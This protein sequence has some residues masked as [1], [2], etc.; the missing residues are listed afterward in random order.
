MDGIKIQSNPSINQSV[1]RSCQFVFR[2]KRYLSQYHCREGK[3]RQAGALQ[4]REP[5]TTTALN[6]GPLPCFASVVYFSFS[7]TSI[8]GPVVSQEITQRKSHCLLTADNVKN[9][10]QHSFCAIS[11]QITRSKLCHKSCPGHKLK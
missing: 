5:G 11:L 7:M 10:N 4:L 2:Q 6:M 9:S 8:S 3:R 1:A